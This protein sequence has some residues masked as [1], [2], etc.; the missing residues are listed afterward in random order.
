MARRSEK[1]C[2]CCGAPA[3]R[4]EQWW[5]RDT[6]FGICRPCF[7]WQSEKSDPEYMRELYGNEGQ[8]YAKKET[9]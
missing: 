7:D 4:F 1:E 3:G 2:C 6:G 5:A 9:A 8:H